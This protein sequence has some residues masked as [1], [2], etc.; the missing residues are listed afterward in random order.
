M[1]RAYVVKI[2]GYDAGRPSVLVSAV[3]GS[4]ALRQPMMPSVMTLTSS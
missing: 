1:K 3:V 2:S 4:P